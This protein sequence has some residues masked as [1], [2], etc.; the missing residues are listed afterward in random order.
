[1]AMNDGGT[2]HL[3]GP[4]IRR[5]YSSAHTENVAGAGGKHTGPL[6]P[7]GKAQEGISEQGVIRSTIESQQAQKRPLGIP[8][9]SPLSTC[10]I[11]PVLAATSTRL[12]PIAHH[13]CY[14]TNAGQAGSDSPQPFRGQARTHFR[15]A[16][17]PPSRLG[18]TSAP[19]DRTDRL[20]TARI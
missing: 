20:R 18:G 1:M 16:C 7:R 12:F 6:T 10:R 9:R 2:P 3:S 14:S 4:P 19:I 11:F 5:K 13:S 17:L 15:I 8:A